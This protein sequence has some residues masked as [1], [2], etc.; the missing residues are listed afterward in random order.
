MRPW[1]ILKLRSLHCR[2]PRSVVTG[3]LSPV[4]SEM[5]LVKGASMVRQFLKSCKLN[6]DAL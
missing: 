3:G 5:G 1:P 6:R 4:A 2:L